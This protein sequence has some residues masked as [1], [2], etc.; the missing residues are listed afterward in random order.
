MD[1]IQEERQPSL[2]LYGW[3][4]NK[5]AVRVEVKDA[6]EQ[7]NTAHYT[8]CRRASNKPSL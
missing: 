8:M 6:K 2:F 5:K 4:L 7:N 1:N 3:L